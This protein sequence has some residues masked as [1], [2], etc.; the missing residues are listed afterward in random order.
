MGGHSELHTVQT[1][2]QWHF[3]N[4]LHLPAWRYM[5]PLKFSMFLLERRPF[6]HYVPLGSAHKGGGGFIFRTFVY[7]THKTDVF[8]TRDMNRVSGHDNYLHIRS[9]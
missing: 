4:V 3:T 5:G 1:V 7:L 6:G 2:Q 8:Y 9:F